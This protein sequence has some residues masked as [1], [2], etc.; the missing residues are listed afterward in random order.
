MIKWDESLST[1]K[2]MSHH[3]QVLKAINVNVMRTTHIPGNKLPIPTAPPCSWTPGIL[4]DRFTWE[5][6]EQLDQFV[7]LWST[8]KAIY[9]QFLTD[10]RNFLP[11]LHFFYSKKTHIDHVLRDIR[12]WLWICNILKHLWTY[13]NILR[14]ILYYQHLYLI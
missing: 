5:R 2:L 14:H 3:L 11:N 4:L 12:I 7:W 8:E 6:G 13:D 1:Y 9:K 10:L